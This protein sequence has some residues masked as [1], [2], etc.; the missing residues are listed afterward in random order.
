M[1]R[2]SIRLFLIPFA[3]AAI[4]VG[5][6]STPKPKFEDCE[7]RCTSLED[8]IAGSHRTAEFAARDGSRHPAETL[9]F[10]GLERDMTVVEL[11]PGGGWYTEILAPYLK[12]KGKLYAA[13][14][15]PDADRE[16]F[17]ESRAKFEKKLA[18]DPKLYGG[19]TVTVLDPPKRVDIAPP[20]SADM[21]LTFRNT[22]NWVQRGAAEAVFAAA[23]E[24][25]K[26]GGAFGVVQHRA[27]KN[28][29]RAAWAKKGYVSEEDTIAMAE[30]AG[31]RLLAESEVNANPKDTKDHPEGVWTLPPRLRL[32]DED[33]A[34]YEAIGESDR[35]TL[36]FV[37]PE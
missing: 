32:G 23:F 26:P 3:A 17:R 16:Y 36:K 5:C 13:H 19:V 15:S 30:A 27:P 10:F 6:A 28:D 14:F 1:H 2:A 12:G 34:K 11:W 29:D 4:A 21:V 35:M 37:K 22:H 8:V 24:A 9:K 18:A 33:R 7:K 20:G 25:L 31:F